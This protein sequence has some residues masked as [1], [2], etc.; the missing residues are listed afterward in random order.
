MSRVVAALEADDGVSL[1]GEQVC[2]LAFS[3]VSPLGSDDH[4]ARH[5]R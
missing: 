2:E 1:L 4:N 3:F 5:R